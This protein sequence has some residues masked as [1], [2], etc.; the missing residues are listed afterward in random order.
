[1]KGRSKG[2][3]ANRSK[4]AIDDEESEMR[5]NVLRVLPTKQE[6]ERLNLSSRHLK[7]LPTH[8]TPELIRFLHLSHNKL[9]TLIGLES[10][11]QLESLSISHNQL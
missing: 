1:M 8:P 11:S 9:T 3:S 10:Y 4:Q 6:R 5:P 2:R 7:L